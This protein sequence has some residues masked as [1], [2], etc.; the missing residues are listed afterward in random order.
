[1]QVFG[2]KAIENQAIFCWDI[3]SHKKVS[4]GYSL[5]ISLNMKRKLYFC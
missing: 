4:I 5:G 1:M 3:F 2:F